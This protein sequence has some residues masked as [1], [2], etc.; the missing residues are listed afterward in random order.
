MCE[1]HKLTDLQEEDPKIIIIV[2]KELFN[3]WHLSHIQIN[4]SLIFPGKGDRL[5]CSMSIFP[6]RRNKLS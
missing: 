2:I 1:K 6:R 3:P 4:Y 5:L